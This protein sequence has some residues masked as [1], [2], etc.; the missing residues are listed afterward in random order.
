MANPALPKF[1]NAS[2]MAV[3]R[4]ECERLDREN[5]ELREQFKTAHLKSPEAQT[6]KELHETRAALHDLRERVR[7]YYRAMDEVINE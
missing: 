5:S 4:Q 2:N 7:A 1:K 6:V 3:L